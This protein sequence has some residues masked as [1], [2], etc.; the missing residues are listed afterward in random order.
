LPEDDAYTRGL[1]ALEL[2]YGYLE[3]GHLQSASD[4][5]SVAMTTS[6][7]AD[8]TYAVLAATWGLAR[9]RMAQGRLH[10]AVRLCRQGLQS[11]TGRADR[12]LPAAI[13]AHVGLGELL[14][15]WNDLGGAVSNLN[16]GIELGERGGL[17]VMLLNSYIVL[18]RVKRAQGNVNGALDTIQAAQQLT[19][20][21][22]VTPLAAK[23][24]AQRARL[25][26]AQGDVVAGVR[27]A[28]ERGLGINDALDYQREFEHTTLARVL[29]AQDR[30]DEALQ[31]LERL[32]VAGETGG[33]VGTLIEIL[34]LQALALQAAGDTAGGVNALARALSLAELE[35][36]VRLFVDEGAPM[37]A[38]LRRV[39]E[40]QNVGRHATTWPNI[41][42]EYLGKLLAATEGELAPPTR[43]SPRGAAESLMEPLS[44]RELE[45]LRLIAS[46]ASNRDIARE[47]F[48]SLATVKTHINH[49]YRKLEVRSRTQAVARAR[50]LKLLQ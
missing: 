30:L 45:V 49:T 28:Q 46:G 50:T 6:G 43:K 27:W 29:I 7:A 42:R 13:Y 39:L 31:L 2:G 36:Y 32:L 8:H 11:A 20:H 41:S 25:D 33:R 47:L 14:Y 38:L 12:P 44:E 35:G 23:A 15:E 21:H 22:N 40:A 19:Q 48:V 26:L 18:S 16:E 4:A 1:S 24:A 5:F 37:A 3:S 10:E 34:A 9:V 17:L